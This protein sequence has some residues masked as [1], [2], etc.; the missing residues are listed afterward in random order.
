MTESHILDRFAHRLAKRYEEHRDFVLLA[1]L[2]TSFRVMVLLLFEPG[3]H[4]LDWEGYY[5]PGASFVQ[6]SDRGLYPIVHYWMEYP[7]LFPW[8]SVIVYRL[9]LFI[10]SWR[11]PGLWYN[12]LLGSALLIFETGNFVLMYLI[13]MKLRGRESAIRCAWLYAG[14]FFPVMTLLFWFENFPLFF[15]L[16]GVYMIIIQRPV[17]GGVA[18]GI[19]FMIKFVPAFVAPV[20]LRVFPGMRQKAAYALAA[21]SV[22]LLIA[23]PFLAT[24]ASF[25]LVPFLHLGSIAPWETIWALLDRNFAGGETT[26]PETRFDL[27]T[28]TA[29]FHESTFPYPIV[30]LAFV[31]VFLVLYT[32]RI[33][34][35]DKMKAVAFCGLSINLFLLFSKGYSPQWIINVLP[36]VVLLMPNLKGVIYALL[37]MG[38]NVLE[39]PISLIL[40]PNHH[41]IF[42]TAVLLRTLVL[43]LLSVD[44]GLILFPS[45]K[46]QRIVHLAVASVTALAVLGSVPVGALA[47]RDY[48]AERYAE[49]PYPEVIQFLKAQPPGAVILTDQKLYDQLFPFL[50][51]QQGLYLLD[52]ER[53]LENTIS[54]VAAQHETIYVVYTG[55]EEDQL[56]G[57]AVETWLSRH[58]F[59]VAVDWAGHARVARY[60]VGAL[61]P[62]V[63]FEGNFSGQIDLQRVASDQGPLRPGDTLRVSLSW[64]ALEPVSQNYA[65]FVHLAGADDHVWAQHDSQPV[66]GFRPTYSWHPGEE[67]TDNHGLALPPDIPPGEYEITVGLYDDATGERLQVIGEE[68]VAVGDMLAVATVEVRNPL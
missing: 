59:P 41:W 17:W 39:F 25:F 55:S 12:L 3:G 44:F 65:V 30:V 34:W 35:Q 45:S 51:R 63:P 6:L 43:V 52:D 4:I 66:G 37:L 20:A 31:V 32:R 5:V 13:A 42:I 58:A 38:A 26:P 62:Y 16:L 29:S 50:A 67:I 27:S 60:S 9:S 68:G 40:I 21:V 2:F 54:T 1:L 14:L 56:F 11:E 36:F 33:D 46:G 61:P 18:A 64:R 23:L 24:S 48:S 10:P 47:L 19:G 7:P 53:L 22:A 15:L 57:P 8:L 49:N 28:V